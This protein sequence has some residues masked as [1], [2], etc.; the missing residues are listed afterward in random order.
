M[1]FKRYYYWIKGDRLKGVLEDLRSAGHRV[2][3]LKKGPVC[4]SLRSKKRICVVFQDAW[5]SGCKRQ[6]SWYGLSSKRGDILLVSPIRL[7]IINC[8]IGGIIEESDFIPPRYAD[9]EDKLRLFQNLRF[10]NLI[11]WR[12]RYVS[13]SEKRIYIRW[14]KRF[15]G[16]VDDYYQLYLS[17]SANH[18]NFISPLLYVKEKDLIIPYSIEHTAS[19]CSCCIELFGILGSEFK[20]RYVIPCPGACIFAELRSDIYLRVT[21]PS[22]SLFTCD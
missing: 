22:Y 21:G 19:V 6:G 9:F 10:S 17:H 5:S 3:S 4:L 7:K 8:L 20:I 1:G 18:S 14:A 16:N 2:V 12:W 11:P 15:R 13:E